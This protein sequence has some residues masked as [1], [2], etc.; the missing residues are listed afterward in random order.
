MGKKSRRERAPR[1]KK[2]KDE[3][4]REA[5]VEVAKKKIENLG[6]SSEV[7]GIKQFYNVCNDYIKSGEHYS[8]KIKLNG[9]K[10]ILEYTLPQTYQ[11]DIGLILKY[12]KNV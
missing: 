3:P 6:L 11:T 4:A 8:G 2:L 1:E 5:A 7:E 10:R 12:D 9:F